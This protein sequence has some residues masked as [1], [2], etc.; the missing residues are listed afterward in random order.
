MA[1]STFIDILGGAC[2]AVPAHICQRVI[3]DNAVSQAHSGGLDRAVV[4]DRVH[5]VGFGE[6]DSSSL[7]DLV[8]SLQIHLGDNVLDVG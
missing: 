8:S 3:R 2:E 6:V 5:S 4:F 7:V 1:S